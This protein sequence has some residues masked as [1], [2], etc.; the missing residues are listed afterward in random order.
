MKKNVFEV[1]W[2]TRT[3]NGSRRYS[4]VFPFEITAVPFWAGKKNQPSCLRAM[5]REYELTADD[6]GR[7]DYRHVRV[8]CAYDSSSYDINRYRI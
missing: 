2:E 7:I 6:K 5:V 8:I 3:S 1:Y 4:R